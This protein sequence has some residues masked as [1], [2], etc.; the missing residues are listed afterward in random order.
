MLNVLIADDERLSREGIRDLISWKEL[1]MQVVHTS[2]D[3]EE[4]LS[5]LLSHPVDILL[6]DIRMPKMDGLTL[7]GQLHRR[8][9]APA[10]ILI[11]GY[12]DF[13]YAQQAIHYGV[14]SYLLKPIRLEELTLALQKAADRYARTR[15]QYP[16]EAEIARYRLQGRPTVH[17]L[18]EDIARDISLDRPEGTAAHLD[19][20][21][22]CILSGGYTVGMARRIAFSAIYRLIHLLG[23][24]S[25]EEI[26]LT[27]DMDR[28]T[29]LSTARDAQ[30]VLLLLRAFVTDTHA[31]TAGAMGRRHRR[32]VQALMASVQER[33]AEPELSLS[34]LA[35]SAGMS[36]NYLSTLFRQQTGKTFSDY[37][38]AYRIEMAR[39]LLAD[40][41]LKIYE[42]AFR[43]GFSDAKYFSKAFKDATG[44]TPLQYRAVHA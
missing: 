40:T 24:F 25:G 1:D 30:E 32:A 34:A 4:A 8:S 17:A 6:T 11:S 42:I 10:A 31:R 2:E 39:A 13:S 35:D 20:L 9:P 28:L 5:Y 19:A 33:Y 21:C 27:G 16:E 3:G 37:L 23:E 29:A 26:S 7:L 18:T 44:Q 14:V 36:P 15:S 43:V 12:D 22:A 38:L 41:D